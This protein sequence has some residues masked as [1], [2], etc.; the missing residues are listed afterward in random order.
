LFDIVQGLDSA[1]SGPT[2]AFCARLRPGDRGAGANGARRLV[3]DKVIIEV[4]LNENMPREANPHVAYSAEEIARDALDCY[5]AGASVIHFHARDPVSG[6]PRLGDPALNLDV[7]RR[8]NEAGAFLAYPTYGDEVKVLDYY[9]INSPARERYR[10]YE[11]IVADP[12]IRLELGPLDLGSLGTNA[13]RTSTAAPMEQFKSINLNDVTD[14]QWIVDFCLRHRLKLTFAAFDT[15]QVRNL[16][17]IIDWGWITEPP[18]VTKFF[19]GGDLLPFGLRPTARALQYLLD[20]TADLPLVW[21]PVVL[22]GNQLP[23]SILSLELGGHVRVGIGDH[24]YEELERPTNAHLVER[25]V[26][27]ARVLGREPA[28][29]DDVRELWGIDAA[30]AG[31]Q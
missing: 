9:V 4:G 14:H 30:R 2:V 16:R 21:L 27:L 15:G 8:C 19:F 20:E 1:V 24:P 10:H 6:E 22:G 26:A 3:V 29:P 28:S 23:L 13:F 17:N 18:F 11:A 31:R 12:D 25:V 5:N 7:M